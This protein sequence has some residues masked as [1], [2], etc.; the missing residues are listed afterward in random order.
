MS[1]IFVDIEQQNAVLV[2]PVMSDPKHIRID[3]SKNNKYEPSNIAIEEFSLDGT[4]LKLFAKEQ[5][6]IVKKQLEELLNY[7]HQE[8]NSL[9]IDFLREEIEYFREKNWVRTL[10]IKPLTDKDL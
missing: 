5:S 10:T 4:A 7:K 2:N 1:D 8:N 6:Y 3:Y 9:Y